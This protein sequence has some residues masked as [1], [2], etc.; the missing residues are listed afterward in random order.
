MEQQPVGNDLKPPE[1][2]RTLATDR[3]SRCTAPTLPA[4]AVAAAH[5]SGGVHP[6]PRGW[7]QLRTL[8]AGGGP[9]V[10]NGS[11]PAAP[12]RTC[13]PFVIG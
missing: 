6:P 4:L 13:G 9:P 8:G 10:P 2:V 1:G 5:P 12:P 7:H 3:Q 11:G